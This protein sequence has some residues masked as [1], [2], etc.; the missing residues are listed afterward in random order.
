LKFA[1]EAKLSTLR[2]VLKEH[3][4]VAN[5]FINH[6]WALDKLPSKKELLKPIVDLPLTCEE[7]TWL[8][9]RL[10]KV[11]A[12]EAV[13]MIL[14]VRR[15]WADEP[16]RITMPVHTGKR[17][18]ISSTI[19]RLEGASSA[20]E[21]DA[22]LILG[23]IGKGI[24]LDIPIRFHD[25]YNRLCVRGKRLNAYVITSDYIQFAFEVETG[26]K[27]TKG[28]SVGVD[29]GINALAT[30][31]DG[32]QLGTD[33]KFLIE[34]IKRCRYGSKRQQKLRR[35]LKQR[36]D[37]IA[38]QIV[39]DPDLR[40]LVTEDLKKLN[41]NTKT[42]RRLVKTMRRSLGIWAY[43]Y[44]LGRLQMSCEDNRV[45]FR[46]VNPAYTSQKCSN[47][48]HTE[49]RNRSGELFLCQGCGHTDNADAN[50]SRNILERLLTG[51]YGAGFK[52]MS[53]A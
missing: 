53:V 46:S 8:S 49:R 50:A 1:T 24:R 26:E 40:L 13:D 16:E 18:S 36:M 33:I 48:G 29:T 21:F 38:K 30:L 25:H 39:Q 19:A 44:W 15:R 10:R 27:R 20:T 51:P 42:K 17:M 32:R 3:G 4:R 28:K 9:A 14:A 41:K 6:F 12:R 7:P 31:S 47:C 45:V 22:W 34:Q 11:A 23:S 52:E 37:E 5:F 43:R 2:F 35:A